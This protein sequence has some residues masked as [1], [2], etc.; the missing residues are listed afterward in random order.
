MVFLCAMQLCAS[1]LPQDN[2]GSAAA[3]MLSNTETSYSAAN[4]TRRDLAEDLVTI[5]SRDIVIGNPQA[6]V[7]VI[8]YSSPTCP[9]CSIYHRTIF[10]AIKEKYIDTGKIAYVMREAVTNK[11]DKYAA[12]LMRCGAKR[13][14]LLHTK[15]VDSIFAMQSTW[16]MDYKSFKSILTKIAQV[17]G[18]SAEEYQMCLKDKEINMQLLWHRKLLDNYERVWGTP[19]FFVNGKRIAAS[20]N[21][22]DQEISK[23]IARSSS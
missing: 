9:H 17:V 7:V 11:L 6:K 19:M 16:A 21:S 10:L 15:L 2:T 4:S 3:P 18:V 8:E 5:T 13:G 20:F 23:A 1:E 22:L 14:P 12:I